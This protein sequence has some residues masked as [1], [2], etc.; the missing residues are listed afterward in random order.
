[1]LFDKLNMNIFCSFAQMKFLLMF[2]GNDK[3]YP[4]G[5]LYLI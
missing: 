3:P 1:M 2:S 5:F 4:P